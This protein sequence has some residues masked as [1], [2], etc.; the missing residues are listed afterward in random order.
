MEKYEKY[1]AD[2]E[3]IEAWLKG[4]EIQLLCNNI[5]AADRKRNW[6]R[7]L[8]GE[9]GNSIIEKLPQATPW[10]EIKAALCSVLGDG[11]PKKRAFETLSSYKPKSKGLGE[12]ASDIMAEAAIASD[13]ADLQ[14]QLGLKTF[15]QAVPKTIGRELRRLHFDSVKE[16]LDEARFLQKVQDEE[17]CESGKIFTVEAE[18]KPLVEEK[19]KVDI[20]QIV[21]ACLKQMQAQQPKKEQSEQPKSSRRKLRCWCCGEEGHTLKEC[22][23]IQ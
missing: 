17:D 14:T 23:V 10:A 6:C 7:A 12:I 8:V 21:E 3:T 18:A 11:E 1:N 16:A 9:A 20:Q 15:L 19:P 5:T 4:F 2:E 13:D 22:P